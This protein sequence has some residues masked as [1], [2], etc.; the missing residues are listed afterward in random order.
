MRKQAKIVIAPDSFKGS[1]SAFEV[2]QA[3]ARGIHITYPSAELITIPLADGG[4]GTVDTMVRATGGAYRTCI[5]M[6][7]LSRPIEARYGI[8]GTKDTAVIE[9]AA[10]SGLPLVPVEL[11]NP[12]HTTTFGTG[13]L[14]RD[15]LEAGHARIILGIGGSATVDGGAGMAQ[16]LG[17]CFFDEAG[18]EITA[19]MTGM[20]I[21]HCCSIRTDRLHPGISQCRIVAACD[22]TN[23]LLGPTGAARIYGPQKGA[24]PEEVLILEKNL[25]H[26]FDL[27][28]S[29]QKLSVRNLPGAGAAGGLGAS[30]YAFLHADLQSG[31]ALLLEAVDFETKVKDADLLITGEGQ[32]DAQTLQGKA[33]SGLLTITR[34]YQVPAIAI[35]GRIQ[36]DI[37]PLIHQG[38]RAAY[39]ICQDRDDPEYSRKNAAKLIEQLIAEVIT[40]HI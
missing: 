7:P 26:F 38:L 19:S 15:A 23:P 12:L 17:V 34:K 11:R 21:G 29:G 10:A 25:H 3:V 32:I 4:E 13:Q 9:M 5:V 20:S 18:E 36:G 37:S 24:N 39:A 1:L 22:V 27:V 35:A 40:R 28:E 33:I 14:I 16:A 2:C 30:L 8:L 31:I 6:D